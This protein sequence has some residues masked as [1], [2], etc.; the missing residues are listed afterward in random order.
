ML[1][2]VGGVLLIIALLAIALL[3]GADVP[4]STE[5]TLLVSVP[6]QVDSRFE[7]GPFAEARRL[8][9]P[10]GFRINVF[11]DGLGT[12]RFMAIGDGGKLYVAIRDGGSV[13]R[14]HDVDGDGTADEV[15][16]FIDGLSKPHSLE[17]WGG[18]LYIASTDRVLRVMDTDGDGQ[19]DRSEVVV[20][21]LPEGGVGHVTRT[22]GFGPD[23][24]M[25]VSIGSVCNICL[26]TEP[27]RAAISRYE[28]DGSGGRVLAHGLRNAVG[29]VWHPG[30]GQL[31]ATDNG[32][33]FLGDDWPPDELNLVREGRDYGWP[34]C[35][36]DRELDPEFGDASACAASEP[37]AFALQAHSAPLG[38]AFYTGDQF[39]A[40]Y[41]GDLLVAFHGSW[42][43]RVPTGYKL[44]RIR[45]D[46]GAPVAIEDFLTGFHDGGSAWGRPVQPIVAPDGSLYV[47]DDHAGAI[48]RVTY[49]GASSR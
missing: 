36:G 7:R 3:A 41:R 26:D 28:P 40:E 23:N 14:L 18:W 38:L 20:P 12:A 49:G 32:P 47:S 2:T 30:T 5:Q 37:P 48:Y 44:V 34:R 19:A 4:G 27:R 46:N 22:V 33:E 9:L 16:V 39:P 1:R 13:L 21:D 43:R 35:H 31:W 25:Y 6:L 11:A 8:H 29:F 24:K 17:F 45:M 42:A 10:D 15:K